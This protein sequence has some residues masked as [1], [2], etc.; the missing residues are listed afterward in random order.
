M[1]IKYRVTTRSRLNTDG[2]YGAWMLVISPLL[3][4]LGWAWYFSVPEWWALGLIAITSVTF[5]G[6]FVLVLIGREYDSVVDET[7]APVDPKFQLGER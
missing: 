7:S 6:G 1:P 5:F 3:Q 4:A 2:V